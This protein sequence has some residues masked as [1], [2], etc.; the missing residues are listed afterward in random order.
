MMRNTPQANSSQ[1]FP[2]IKVIVQSISG[3][4]AFCMDRLNRSYQIN[5]T[6]TTSGIRP[7]LGETW[8]VN[9]AAGGYYTFQMRISAVLPVV[10]GADPTTQALVLLGLAQQ[11]TGV[12][13]ASGSSVSQ[14]YCFNN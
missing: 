9:R 3:N 5:L 12:M 6:N 1:G 2:Q 14:G 7:Q 8:Y 11:A 13:S 4:D 10:Q